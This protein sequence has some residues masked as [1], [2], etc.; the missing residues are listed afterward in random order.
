MIFPETS[1]FSASVEASVVS[2][3]A[4]VAGSAVVL[5]GAA[6][7]YVLSV[8]PLHPASPITAA[9]V[10][11]NAIF[12]FIFKVLRLFLKKLYFL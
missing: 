2:A 10:K 7:V 8:C 9:V 12:L 5:A 6:V 1:F 3:F 11:I 4:C